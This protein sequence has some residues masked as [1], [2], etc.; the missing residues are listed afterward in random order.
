MTTTVKTCSECGGIGCGTC[1]GRGKSP[2]RRLLLA[3]DRT[4]ILALPAAERGKCPTCMG[5]GEVHSHNPRCWDCHGIGEVAAADVEELQ[6]R[7]RL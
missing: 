3:L 5:T 1:Q 4:Q 6:R 7:A 2:A